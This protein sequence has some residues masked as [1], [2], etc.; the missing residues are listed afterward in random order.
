MRGWRVWPDG[1]NAE[2]PKAA[3]ILGMWLPWLKTLWFRR[4]ESLT[5]LMLTFTK[6]Y[7]RVGIKGFRH[8]DDQ[9]KALLFDGLPRRITFGVYDSRVVIYNRPGELK[10]LAA[11][12]G[13]ESN[14]R[15][16]YG[17]RRIYLGR[18][19]LSG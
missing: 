3:G 10:D 2:G 16:L 17:H 19:R 14:E 9:F 13:L 6:T 4:R 11:R 8:G 15:P 18:W 1:A 7:G 12:T 5:I